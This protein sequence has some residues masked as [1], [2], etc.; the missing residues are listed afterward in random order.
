[1][2]FTHGAGCFLAFLGRYR[3]ALFL[4]FLNTENGVRTPRLNLGGQS[5]VSWKGGMAPSSF[6]N[7]GGCE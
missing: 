5:L 3:L 6:M 2:A 4:F 1:M 7:I